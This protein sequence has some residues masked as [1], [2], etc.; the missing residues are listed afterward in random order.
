MP[1]TSLWVVLDSNERVVL[2][3]DTDVLLV[4]AAPPRVSCLAVDEI[5]LAV[6]RG[7]CPR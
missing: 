3:E 2:T 7:V 1:P 6:Y 5:W 4:L